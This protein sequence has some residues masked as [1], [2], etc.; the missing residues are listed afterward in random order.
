MNLSFS[1]AIRKIKAVKEIL[2]RIKYQRVVF[3]LSWLLAIIAT[4]YYFYHNLI[5]T[6]GD[7]ESHLNIVK[8]VVHSLTPGM[9]AFDYSGLILYNLI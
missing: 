3:Y 8:R 5:V 9:A 1:I 4:N 7:A 2:E 6:Y